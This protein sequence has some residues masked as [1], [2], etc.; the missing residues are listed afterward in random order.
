MRL[1]EMQR[2]AI[3]ELRRVVTMKIAVED[4]KK[5]NISVNCKKLKT[6]A[7]KRGDDEVNSI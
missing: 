2:H 1:W 7:Q 4:G 3:S 6:S 5:C